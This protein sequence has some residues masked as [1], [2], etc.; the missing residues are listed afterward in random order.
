MKTSIIGI[1]VFLILVPMLTEA[2]SWKGSIRGEGEVVKRTLDIDPFEAVSLGFSGDIIL[3]QGNTQKVE[4]EA[5]ANIIE[6]IKTDV[7]G[8]KWRVNYKKGVKQSKPVK[9][10]I[11]LPRLT[12]AGISGSGSMWTTGKFTNLGD[13]ETYISGSGDLRLGI[14]ADDIEAHI[15]GSG[16]ISLE[17]SG[18]VLD[19]HISGS[20]DVHAMD[21][22]VQN[23][24]VS[25]SGS[26][27]AGVYASNELNVRISG[28][29]D[30]TYKGDAQKV[31]SSVSG[32]G[33]VRS[34]N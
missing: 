30:V 16:T 17:G 12:G 27:D 6:N 31:R 24:E 21:L 34:A 29:G 9:V 11:T 14:D 32:S 18:Q 2:Q 28:S 10:Y 3:T 33:D 8:G 5:Q 23:C 13:L 26:G 15:S 20:G 22:Q 19:V 4:V 7:S 1:C 25:I